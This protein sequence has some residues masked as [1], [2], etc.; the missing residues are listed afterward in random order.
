MQNQYR[1]NRL[2][3]EHDYAMLTHII[4]VVIVVSGTVTAI[5]FWAVFAA[6]F[7]K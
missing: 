6:M 5:V 4:E 3:R 7:G 1:I 2:R